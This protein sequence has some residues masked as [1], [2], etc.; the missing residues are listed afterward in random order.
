M[1]IKKLTLLAAAFFVTAQAQ[2]GLVITTGNNPQPDSENVL[3]NQPGSVSS[4]N[5][6]TG[7]TNQTGLLV[8]FAG[9]EDLVTPA[10]GQARVAAQDGT[11]TTFTV[12]MPGSTFNS[13]I[14]HI[15]SSSTST[16]TATIT[17]NPFTGSGLTGTFSIFGGLSEN[18][19]TVYA[20]GIDRLASVQVT[21]SIALTDVR[22]NI[23]GGARSTSVPEPGSLALLG[24]GLVGLGMS[25]RRKAN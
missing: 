2:A 6:V 11:L 4:G 25:R 22:Q 9:T 8:T 5:P 17:V 16:G 20:T 13:Y 15:L 10:T 3:F 12:A 19:F 14:F 21:S 1:N 24:L 18:F 23:I 7:T